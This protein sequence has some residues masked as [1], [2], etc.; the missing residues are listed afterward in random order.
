M[1]SPTMAPNY[2]LVREVGA[3]DA[4]WTDKSKGLNASDYEYIHI[5]VV[6]GTVLGDADA[7]V[8]YW[9]EAAGAYIP[10]VPDEVFP[11]PGAGIHYEFSVNARGRQLMISL[12][13]TVAA[14]TKVYASGYKLDHTV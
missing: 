1:N 14:G 12:T 2:L 11:S 10:A 4:A 3:V 6:Q 8:R 9:C 13:G 7:Q 5:Q